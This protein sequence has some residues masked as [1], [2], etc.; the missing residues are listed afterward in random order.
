VNQQ[1]I[2]LTTTACPTYQR[3][4][5]RPLSSCRLAGPPTFLSGLFPFFSL[6]VPPISIIGL[7]LPISFFHCCLPSHGQVCFF[8]P[9]V[10]SHSEG[11]VLIPPIAFT[12]NVG[13]H[14]SRVVRVFPG[15]QVQC[16]EMISQLQNKQ[17]R[18]MKDVFKCHLDL[19]QSDN[20]N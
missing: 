9:I 13:R 7:A 6:P 3:V 1:S 19:R 14:R 2:L 20:P 17:N 12:A 4:L 15:T 5:L 11:T 18:T 8:P 10:F 16:Y